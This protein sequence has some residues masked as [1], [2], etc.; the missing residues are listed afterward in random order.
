MT[1]ALAA[2]FILLVAG[3]RAGG[4]AAAQAVT[5]TVVAVH[6][7]HAISVRTSTATVR[8]RLLGVDCPEGG[9][10]YS[11]RA[12]RFTSEMVFKKTVTE[13]LDRYDRLLGRGPVGRRG[14]HREAGAQR[15][16]AAVSPW[17]QDRRIT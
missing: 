14:R 8:V 5:G 12:K 13:G 1:R 2:V 15:P 11:A 3:E 6:D 7:G 4:R 17:P 16:G 10:P 9:Q